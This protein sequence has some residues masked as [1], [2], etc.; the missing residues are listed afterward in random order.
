MFSF[1]IAFFFPQKW[2]FL[3]GDGI[4]KKPVKREAT[5]K[6][7]DETEPVVDTWQQSSVAA[8]AGP[9]TGSP[10][11]PW[12]RCIYVSTTPRALKFNHSTT[13]ALKSQPWHALIP[14]LS[15]TLWTLRHKICSFF[16]TRP[17]PPPPRAH[18]PSSCLSFSHALAPETAPAGH[19]KWS[20]HK[21]QCGSALR[22]F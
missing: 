16:R 6:V 1:L 11:V 8:S 22:Y 10:G 13:R 20:L 14:E 9:N 21:L 18:H 7:S 15:Q 5:G 4:F 17:P 12:T 2:V 19:V 3:V